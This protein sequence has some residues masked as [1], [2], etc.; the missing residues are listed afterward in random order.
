LA[1]GLHTFLGRVRGP[2]LSEAIVAEPDARNLSDQKKRSPLLA[3]SIIS[4]EILN[5]SCVTSYKPFI[6]VDPTV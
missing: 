3:I 1:D 6:D 4:F 5:H 2:A